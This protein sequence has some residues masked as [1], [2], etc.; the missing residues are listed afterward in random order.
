M[1]F[2]DYLSFT[3]PAK[4]QARRD[5]KSEDNGGILLEGSLD[6]FCTRALLELLYYFSLL[7]IA[8]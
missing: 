5:G 4:R 3:A 6:G 1:L 2:V 8:S 7:G